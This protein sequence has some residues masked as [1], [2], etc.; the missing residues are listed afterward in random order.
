[1]TES[2]LKL[3]NKLTITIAGYFHKPL[4]NITELNAHKNRDDWLFSPVIPVSFDP[5]FWTHDQFL[6]RILR[7][8]RCFLRG[9]AIFLLPDLLHRPEVHID[10]HEY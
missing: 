4:S 8:L 10:Q 5:N 6:N 2:C 7:R 9:L 3:P 1:M